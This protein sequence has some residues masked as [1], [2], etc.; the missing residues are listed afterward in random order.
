MVPLMYSMSGVTFARMS[1]RLFA[2]CGFSTSF[3]RAASAPAAIE[4]H[5]ALQTC[6]ELQPPSV[7][8]ANAIVAGRADKPERP[9]YVGLGAR[10]LELRRHHADD[11][12]GALDD[13]AIGQANRLAERLAVAEQLVAT[14]AR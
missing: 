10:I 14:D 7:T 1:R 5:A 11:R 13:V 6:N 2:N 4:R 12:V 3:A 8:L 9:P